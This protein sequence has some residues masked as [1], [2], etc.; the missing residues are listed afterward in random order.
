MA[1]CPTMA[2]QR[3]V[4]LCLLMAGQRVMVEG[5]NEGLG[6]NAQDIFSAPV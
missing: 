5:F 4:A 1:L 3:V 2:G 6:L